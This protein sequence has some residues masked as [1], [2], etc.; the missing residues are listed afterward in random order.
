MSDFL[1]GED[2]EVASFF[3]FQD[4]ITAVLG[5]LILIALQLSFTINVV[6][7]EKGNKTSPVDGLVVPEE[8]YEELH[9][10]RMEME[11]RL[12]VLRERNRE[13][14][15]RRRSSEG[16]VLSMDALLSS[17]EILN[18][19]WNN[20]SEQ[21][22][23]LQETVRE[24]E[25]I[26]QEQTR[27]LGLEDTQQLI[28][29]MTDALESEER[30]NENLDKQLLDLRSE[31]SVANSQLGSERR[32]RDSIW[33]IP[34]RDP[35]GKNPLLVTVDGRNLRFEEFD[36]PESLKVLSSRSLTNSF[37]AGVK[38]CSPRNYKINFLFKPSGAKY[39]DKIIE[40]AKEE[41][42]QV[43]YDPIEES[44]EVLF[45]LPD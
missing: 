16:T 24:R 6:H 31:I 34:E 1:R 4:V 14:L 2:E 37:E 35:D 8:E 13:L 19:E 41:G 18:A 21:F 29:K 32:K 9:Q 40:L 23:D 26:L 28:V 25:A 27:G 7:G 12:T 45:S 33:L 5:I 10:R 3:A 39:F 17:V 43:G 42:F 44:K 20:L 38:G 30:E 22:A 36:K 15:E 11:Q